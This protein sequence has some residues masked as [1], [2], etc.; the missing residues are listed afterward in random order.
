MKV[1]P[2]RDFIPLSEPF[3]R[4]RGSANNVTIGLVV[5]A[6][7]SLSTNKPLFRMIPSA[8]VVRDF[9]TAASWAVWYCHHQDRYFSNPPRDGYSLRCIIAVD[10]SRGALNIVFRL[11]PDAGNGS[12]SFR[13]FVTRIEDDGFICFEY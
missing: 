9:P 8:A 1:I 10:A 12:I 11:E 6:L 4:F 5:D 13:V 3:V 2:T 7:E